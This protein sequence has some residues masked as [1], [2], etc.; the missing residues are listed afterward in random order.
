MPKKSTFDFIAIFVILMAVAHAQASNITE[1][2]LAHR[3]CLGFQVGFDY[4]RSHMTT[5]VRQHADMIAEPQRFAYLINKRSD[6]FQ[7]LGL[8]IDHRI[9]DDYRLG[10]LFYSQPTVSHHRFELKYETKFLTA[11]SRGGL[12]FLLSL[13]LERDGFWKIKLS[14]K[15][16]VK[17]FSCVKGKE[18]CEQEKSKIEGVYAKMIAE[19]LV[20]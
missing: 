2:A 10:D 4:L 6:N 5:V 11:I 9:F 15:S 20:W 14:G 12:Q 7:D 16:S 8:H 3:L 1:R 13:D 17:D 19:P 18:V